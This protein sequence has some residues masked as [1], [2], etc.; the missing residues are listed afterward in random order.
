M[1]STVGIAVLF[2]AVHLTAAASKASVV[3]DTY[4]GDGSVTF[5]WERTAQSFTVPATPDNELLNYK[6]RLAPRSGGG[7]VNFSIVPWGPT[8][9]TGAV[10]F[11]QSEA[12]PGAG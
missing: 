4:P 8:G 3:I 1:R 10:V 12:W 11:S 6:F 5:G 2:V 9:P 7:T